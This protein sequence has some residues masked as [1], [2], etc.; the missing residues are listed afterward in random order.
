MLYR[1]LGEELDHRA[2]RLGALHHHA[3]HESLGECLP[4]RRAGIQLAQRRVEPLHR[5]R[6]V[7]AEVVTARARG[8]LGRLRG[9]EAAHQHVVRLDP[10]AEGAARASQSRQSGPVEAGEVGRVQ[11]VHE[12]QLHPDRQ[13]AGGAPTDTGPRA[14]WRALAAAARCEPTAGARNR[15]A[16]PSHFFFMTLP[17]A[18]RELSFLL[19]LPLSL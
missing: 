14:A 8:G 5:R 7:E 15:L 17:A 4:A 13:A 9:K 10:R 18:A 6:E 16:V 1:Q 19:L 12:A 2:A 3:L 11:R